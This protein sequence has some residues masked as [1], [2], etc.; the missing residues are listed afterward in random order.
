MLLSTSLPKV[1]IHKWRKYELGRVK[2]YESLGG[3][4]L[5]IFSR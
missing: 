4:I 1:A 2:S 3:D 5:V